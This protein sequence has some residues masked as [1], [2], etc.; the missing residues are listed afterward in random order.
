MLL[1]VTERRGS[2]SWDSDSPKIFNSLPKIIFSVFTL[3]IASALLFILFVNRPVYDEVFHIFDI[4]TY[5]Q[6]GVSVSTVR[7]QRDAPGPGSFIWMAAGVR[8]LNGGELRDAR[9]AILLGWVLLVVGILVSAPHSK[10]SHLWYG[11]L[12]TTLVF[13]H[14]LT[15]TATL[16]TEGPALLF[17]ILGTLVW[18]EAV[19]RPKVS[20]RV[21]VLGIIGGLGMGAAIISRQY[22]VALLP[23]AAV[24][25]LYLLRQRAA[26]DRTVWLASV[27]FSLIV[28]VT[29]LLLLVA[30]WRNI[31][32]PGIATGT[33]YEGYHAGVG[34]NFFRPLVAAFC[35]GFYLLP[36][37]FPALKCV[38]SGRRWLVLLV[39]AIIGIA[40]VPFRTFL[41]NIGVL[42]S[43][44][45]FAFRFPAVGIVVFGSLAILITYNAIALGLLMWEK[46]QDMLRCP[47]V[48]FAILT[49]LFFVGEQVGVGGNVPFY[50]RYELQLAPFLGLI[51]FFLI[52][53]V[54]LSRLSVL[55][56]MYLLSQEM[57][58]RLL[59]IK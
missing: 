54:T 29:P 27:T 23:A 22:N 31:S 50:D 41:V 44:L 24:L 5:A 19:L 17:A 58:W 45:E 26:E 14:S 33:S 56:G 47:P 18:T 13:P 48:I 10:F 35:T 32:S 30:V 9:L 3:S 6:N 40:A 38:Q 43:L 53:K 21:F 36:L 12:L 39:A 1:A 8:L 2:M 46:R 4:N 25:A 7:A 55:M 28:A 16:L 49:V 51:A 37:T 42:H 34:L 11:A 20:S 59:F 52:P 57:L 15:A